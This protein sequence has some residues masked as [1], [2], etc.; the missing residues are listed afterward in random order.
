[1]LKKKVAPFRNVAN[2]LPVNTFVDGTYAGQAVASSG[3]QGFVFT[4]PGLP[5]G[6]HSLTASFAGDAQYAPSSGGPHYLHVVASLGN[7]TT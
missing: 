3:G 1:L 5:I 6:T 4:Y 7:A 2:G